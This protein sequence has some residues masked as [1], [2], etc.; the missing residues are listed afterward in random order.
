MARRDGRVVDLDFARRV[1]A[2]RHLARVGEVMRREPSFT[3]DEDAQP[4]RRVCRRRA[5][6]IGLRQCH[7][8][9]SYGASPE[10]FNVL[11]V[12]GWVIR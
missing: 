3:G 7:S 10:S 2:D 8:R 9:G 1:A 5:L 11:E 4:P 12:R 6:R